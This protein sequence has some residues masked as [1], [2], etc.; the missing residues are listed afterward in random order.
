M[1]G[2]G[3]GYKTIFFILI[4][5]HCLPV[6]SH[7][8]MQHKVHPSQNGLM[9]MVATASNVRQFLSDV[10]AFYLVRSA[11]SPG[12]PLPSHTASSATK[13][14]P[15]IMKITALYGRSVAGVSPLIICIMTALPHIMDAS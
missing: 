6:L 7:T 1:L 4:P 10:F 8:F 9:K 11:S 3:L 5:S 15:T 13:T 12:L 14:C 2:P